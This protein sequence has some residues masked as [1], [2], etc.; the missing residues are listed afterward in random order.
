MSEIPHLAEC[1]EVTVFALHE[2]LRCDVSGWFDF[3]RLFV[4]LMELLDPFS[5]GNHLRGSYGTMVDEKKVQD[6]MVSVTK[7]NSQV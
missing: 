3:T 4:L 5:S 1:C 2:E 7:V 6:N